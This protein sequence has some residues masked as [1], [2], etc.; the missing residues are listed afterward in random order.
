MKTNKTNKMKQTILML[1]IA[2]LVFSMLSAGLSYGGNERDKLDELNKKIDRLQSQLKAGK[3]QESKL[4]SEIKDLDALI[5]AA[6]GEIK[7]LGK[8]IVKLGEKIGVAE[9]ELRVKQEEIA[10]QSEEMGQRIRTMYKN[11]DVGILEVLLGSTS[12]LDFL[13][14]LDMA[15]RIFDGDVTFLENLET[16]YA[17]IED[18]KTRLEKLKAELDAKRG[19]GGQAG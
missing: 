2:L 11:G 16:Q 4:A 5:R 15:Q 14:N 6:E 7:D 17:K 9:A 1:T 8:E 18:H 12:M 3:A 10:D 13:T 19:R